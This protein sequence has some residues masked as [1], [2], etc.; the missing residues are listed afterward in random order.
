MQKED[1]VE[2]LRVLLEEFPYWVQIS[3]SNGVI[4]DVISDQLPTAGPRLGSRSHHVGFV[5]RKVARGGE[6][7]FLRV[8][9]FS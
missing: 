3:S 7:G 5:V 8:L 6:A 1:I 2:N 4:A 9:Q